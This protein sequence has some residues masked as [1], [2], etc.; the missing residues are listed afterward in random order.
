MPEGKIPSLAIS[1]PA[2][3][4]GETIEGLVLGSLAVLE[5]RAAD[6][7][8]VIID[9]G[10]RDQTGPILDRLARE[11]PRVRVLRHETNQGFGATLR[12]VFYQ[13]AKDAIFFIPGDAQIPPEEIDRLLPALERADLVIGWRARRM[14]GWIRGCLSGA[15]NL[16]ISA[17]LLRR[18]HDVDSVVLVR[19][20]A[21]EAIRLQADSAFLHAELVLEAQRRGFRWVEVPIGHRERIRGSTTVFRARVLLPALRDLLRHLLA[22]WTI[23]V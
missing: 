17:L 2:Y 8:V 14:D 22:R 7:E 15:Y 4:E 19:R 11:H 3:N 18:V 5:S 13:P 20:R 9:D 6:F 21:L 23:R 1:I 12:E 10:S 16:L